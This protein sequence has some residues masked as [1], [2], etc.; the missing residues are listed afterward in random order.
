MAWKRLRDEKGRE[1]YFNTKTKQSQWTMPDSL[2]KEH[3]EM[4]NEW[5]DELPD[6]TSK[7]EV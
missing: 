6:A 2:L 5:E 4:A 7:V 1:Y 3:E